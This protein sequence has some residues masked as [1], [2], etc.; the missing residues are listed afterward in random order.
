[1]FV[2]YG[3]NALVKRWKSGLGLSGLRTHRGS[4]LSEVWLLHNLIA[5]W[6]RGFGLVVGAWQALGLIFVGLAA[7][8]GAFRGK[9]V[10]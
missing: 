5:C 3:L 2:P 9:F 6:D 7:K 1:M 4:A 8:V 10:F